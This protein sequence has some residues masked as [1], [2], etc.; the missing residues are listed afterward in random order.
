MA[1]VG[2]LIFFL[3]IFSFVPRGWLF[4]SIALIVL[5]LVAYFVQEFGPRR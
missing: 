5:S 1:L 2:I 3:S 4:V